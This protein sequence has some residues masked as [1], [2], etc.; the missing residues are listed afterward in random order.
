[1][2]AEA[3]NPSGLS[4]KLDKKRKRQAEESSKK[5]KA[6][7]APSGNA[8]GPSN[9]KRKNGKP[10]P[11][12]KGGKDKTEDA[13]QKE[14][15]DTKQTETKGGIDEAIGKMDG[16]LLADHFMQKAKRHN[17]ELTAVELSDLSV[18]ESSFLDTSSFDSPRQLENLPAFLKAFS[19]KGSDLSKP[20][21]EKGT[22]HTLVVSPSG[23]RAA[24]AVRALRTFQTKESPIGKLFA[25]HIKL[26]EAKQFLDRSRIAI[27]GGTP[28]RIS[29]L[30][31]AG[32]LKLDELQRIV[33]DGSYV[34][35][36]QRGIFDMKE[37]HLPL[38]QLLTRPEFRERYGTKEKRIQILV[39]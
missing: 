30:I 11:N 32:S 13:P 6:G 37:T 12:K 19:P 18:P 5:A 9:K 25:K 8:D 14:Q 26:E 23:L 38:L 34:D 22:P 33:I 39:F 35:Q 29:D 24:D 3:A 20:S 17:K 4:A 15:R 10:K 36:K 1:M 16:R 31:T 27:G 7:V 28:A 2:P 21:V